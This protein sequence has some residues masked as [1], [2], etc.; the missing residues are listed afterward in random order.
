MTDFKQILPL[1]DGKQVI[2]LPL[3]NILRVYYTQMM[4]LIIEYQQETGHS[5]IV[6]FMDWI[7]KKL[8]ITGAIL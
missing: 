1:T 3:E 5:N 6:E 7:K 8:E 2:Y 4:P